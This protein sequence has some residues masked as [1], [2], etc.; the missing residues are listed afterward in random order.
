MKGDETGNQQTRYGITRRRLRELLPCLLLDDFSHTSDGNYWRVIH[1]THCKLAKCET[2]PDPVDQAFIRHAVASHGPKAAVY[3]LTDGLKAKGRLTR[4]NKF[5]LLRQLLSLR[6][7]GWDLVNGQ[8][9][10]SEE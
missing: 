9:C 8:A 6:S 10:C 3:A 4:V 7:E 5:R 1:F 2:C